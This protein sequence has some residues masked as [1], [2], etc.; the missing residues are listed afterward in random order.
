MKSNLIIGV[1]I[2]C[3]DE[4]KGVIF[5]PFFDFFTVDEYNNIG[6]VYLVSIAYGK[7][8]KFRLQKSR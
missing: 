8:W 6:Y 2:S 3:I 5:A 4:E 1:F 7:Y